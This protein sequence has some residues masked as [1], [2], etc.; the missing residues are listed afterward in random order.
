MR[1]LLAR[2]LINICDTDNKT[3]V[4]FLLNAGQIRLILFPYTKLNNKTHRLLKF[5]IAYFVLPRLNTKKIPNCIRVN[6]MNNVNFSS[7][8]I[9]RVVA[10][11]IRYTRYNILLFTP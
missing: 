6:A 8:V 5:S 3:L 4:I 9:N 10:I 2:A 7:C 11:L 1:P